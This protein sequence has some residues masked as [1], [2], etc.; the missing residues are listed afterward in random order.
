[1]NGALKDEL[2][3]K[4]IHFLGLAYIPAIIV[5][6]RDF[7]SYAV[8]ILTVSALIFEFAVRKRISAIESLLRDYE[9]KRVPGYIHTGVAFSI[10]TLIFSTEACITAAVSA[11]VGDGVSGIVKRFSHTLAIPAFI[12][13][14]FL[15]TL[16]L[17]V[18]YP[19]SLISIAVASLFDGRRLEDNFTIPIATAATYQIVSQTPWW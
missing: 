15:L 1:M 3:R 16:L 13:S 8:I 7:V 9:K 12:T 18:S 14:A 10:V 19:F 2:R 5:F 11:F 17:P 4:T 6:G